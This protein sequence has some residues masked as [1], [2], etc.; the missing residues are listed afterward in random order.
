MENS[1]VIR[2]GGNQYAVTIDD[3]TK[4]VDLDGNTIVSDD[5]YTT[6]ENAGMDMDKFLSPQHSE[7]DA[8]WYLAAKC[9]ANYT[10]FDVESHI[11]SNS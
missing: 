4:N 5:D 1:K 7:G 9:A 8:F 6:L 11:Y 2:L 3:N 10:G